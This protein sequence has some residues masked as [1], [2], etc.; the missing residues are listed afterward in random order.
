MLIFGGE[1][2]D[3]EAEFAPTL[4][5]RSGFTALESCPFQ[6]V[7]SMFLSYLTISFIIFPLSERKTGHR[8]WTLD[9]GSAPKC[10]LHWWTEL[11]NSANCQRSQQIW[12]LLWQKTC[13]SPT[14]CTWCARC[15][16]TR[17]WNSHLSV[18]QNSRATKIE[19]SNTNS[20]YGQFFAML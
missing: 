4:G 16:N 20:T 13:Q 1:T 17:A 11:I 6:S 2:P 9:P 5:T 14:Y 3:D 18:A 10:A 19:P 8:G 7:S 12:K 15:L